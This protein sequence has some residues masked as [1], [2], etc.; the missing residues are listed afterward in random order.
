MARQTRKQSSSGIYHIVIRGIGK[1]ILFEDDKDYMRFLSILEKYKIE[2]SVKVY[3]YCLMENHVHLLIKVDNTIPDKFMKK[4]ENSY[5][6]YY[7]HR[8]ERVGTLFQERYKSE[9]VEND[10]YFAVVFRYILQN[11]EK[12]GFAKTSQYKWSS[13]ADF[14]VE[15]NLTDVEFPLGFFHGRT[16]LLDYVTQRNSDLCLE[17]KDYSLCDNQAKRIIREQIGLKSGTILQSLGKTERNI[18]LK[19]LKEHGL[20]VRQIER[21]TG[22]SRGII[23]NA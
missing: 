17:I 2:E 20:S 9:P 7:N 8:Y 14:T 1:Q 12:A 4:I 22:V 19:K 13:Y 6:F 11:P 18:A 21:L 16:T 3:A 10:A 5:V 23:Q 15:S